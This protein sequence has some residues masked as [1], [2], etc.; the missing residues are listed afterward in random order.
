MTHAGFLGGGRRVRAPG[1][2]PT[3]GFPP[4]PSYFISRSIVVYETT[5]IAKSLP[6]SAAANVKIQFKLP[7]RLGYIAVEMHKQLP[8]VL[9]TEIA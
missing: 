7:V 3:E 5:Q 1:I 2:P 8:L 9:Q 6:S 4:N